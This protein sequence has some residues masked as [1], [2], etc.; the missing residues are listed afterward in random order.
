[1]LVYLFQVDPFISLNVDEDL[2]KAAANGD[3][4]RCE[5]LL[6]IPN[7]NVKLLVSST[8]VFR[9]ILKTKLILGKY[10]FCRTY[11]FTSR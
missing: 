7:S 3:I 1:M 11:S 4:A 6:S 10:N 9:L 5:Y 8:I 2:V